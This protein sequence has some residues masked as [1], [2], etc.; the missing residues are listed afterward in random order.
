MTRYFTNARVVTP[1][2]VIEEGTVVVDGPTIARVDFAGSAPS[3]ANEVVDCAG[4][5]LLPG[6]IDLH[7][8][9]LEKELEPRPFTRFSL[10]GSLRSFENRLVGSGI[11][12]IYHAIPFMGKRNLIPTEERARP[13]LEAIRDY[14]RVATV[15]HRVHARYEM[16]ETSYA[17]VVA[18]M[19]ECGL[20]DM[21]SL[22]DHTP[23]QGQYQDIERFKKVSSM[24]RRMSVEEI[25]DHIAARQAKAAHEAVAERAAY[26]AET[27]VRLGVPL[28]SHD[29]DS[30]AK[31]DRV[32]AL[33]VQISEFPVAL[34]VAA[35]A[36]SAGMHVVV[37]APNIVQGKSNS[38]NL[39]AEDAL[40]SGA[41]DIVCSDYHSPA[42]LDSAFRLVEHGAYELPEA[43]ARMSAN[44]ARA[45]GLDEELGSIEAGKR[46]DLVRV[47]VSDGVPHVRAVY[48]DGARVY[49]RR[50][51][52]PVGAVADARPR[53]TVR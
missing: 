1:D 50:S 22:M 28:A 11:T 35:H 47:E 49:E 33:G 42:M 4:D 37:G 6:L 39:R 5:W 41:A 17:E 13:T 15:R 40:R 14:D 19:M 43:V 7:N 30:I 45:V 38:G 25:D 21:V 24:L 32:R 44:A 34:E 2:A 36:A 20:I 51:R 18:Q 31:V 23:G 10:A 29:D 48:V 46:A 8:D 52:P 12:T 26:V 53:V 27:A 9:G 16:P 3:S